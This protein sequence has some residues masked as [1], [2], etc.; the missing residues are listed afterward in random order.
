MYLCGKKKKVE[1]KEIP[2]YSFLNK[3]KKLLIRY[4]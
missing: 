4:D 2:C 1:E 3:L